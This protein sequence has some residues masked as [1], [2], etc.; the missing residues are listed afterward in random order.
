MTTVSQLSLFSWKNVD[1]SPEILRLARVLD[2]L[3]DEPVIAALIRQRKKKRN[4]YPVEAV[5]NSLIA[6]VV[7]GH[8]G[9]ES[10]R[11]E[12]QRNAELRQVCGFDPLLGDKAVPPAPV[13]S[14]FLAKL[15]GLRRLIDAMF[16]E[17]V[18][19]VGALLPDFGKELAVDGKAIQ[20]HGLKDADA[21]WSA[22]KTY[23]TAGANGKTHKHTK[24]WFG[25]KLHLM[26][27]VNY[28]L[29]VAFELTRADVSETTR[30]MPMVEEFKDKHPE[31]YERAEKISADK[32][33]DDGSD[34]ADLYD[35][36]GI[37]PLIDTRDMQKQEKRDTWQ[38]L[39][40]HRHDTIYFDGTGRVA[41]KISPFEPDDDKA[42]APMQ[43]MGFEKDRA[44]L[45]FRCPAKTRGVECKNRDACQCKLAARDGDFGRVVRVPLS[46][47]RRIFMPAHRHSRTFTNAYKKRSS[48]ERVNSRVDQV[49]GFERHFI[50]GQAKMQLRVGLTMIVMLATAVAWIRAG[51]KEKARSLFKAA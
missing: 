30:L 17:L 40:P 41:C 5:W 3:P 39:D 46:R 25:Y 10:L 22:K 20:T 14:R 35:E 48:V 34:K 16:H 50:R 19:T 36:H 21:A 8:N 18:E 37:V 32:G 51:E 28:E 4:D 45:K 33:Y 23:L 11:R 31:L 2:T 15:Y 43:F 24:W 9:V 47:D 1:A 27:D 7:F 38:A 29:P 26:V 44:T 42:F 49:Y 6:G 12:L 13:Y